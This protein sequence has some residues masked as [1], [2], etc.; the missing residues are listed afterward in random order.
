MPS[1]AFGRKRWVG[2]TLHRAQPMT[3]CATALTC[4][5][6]TTAARRA[7]DTSLH[8]GPHLPVAGE[9]GVFFFLCRRCRAWLTTYLRGGA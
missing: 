8:N 5:G 4:E 9:S 7:H 3:A 2:P 1:P 6:R